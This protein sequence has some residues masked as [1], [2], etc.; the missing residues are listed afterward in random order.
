MKLGRD[1]GDDACPLGRKTVPEYRGRLRRIPRGAEAEIATIF[2]QCARIRGGSS[3]VTVIVHGPRPRMGTKR[4]PNRHHERPGFDAR[5]FS[6]PAVQ[7]GARHPRRSRRPARPARGRS[8]GRGAGGRP[9]WATWRWAS[10]TPRSRGPRR[11][12]A[13]GSMCVD[14]RR[15][16]RCPGSGHASSSATAEGGQGV[17]RLVLAEDG[18]G[19]DAVRDRVL[20]GNCRL[21]RAIAGQL[22]SGD[23]ERLGQALVP[24]RDG[25]LE[26]GLEH[27]DGRP[28][29]WAAPSTTMASAVRC[30]S[31]SPCRKIW[32][33]A[34][35]VATATASPPIR[36]RRTRSLVRSR[37]RPRDTSCTSGPSHTST[38]RCARSGLRRG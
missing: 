17:V 21:G 35:P 14:P 31:V 12:A 4:A 5:G 32:T 7:P 1:W 24:E 28:S 36:K 37:V 6:D 16:R 30:S 3:A 13:P 20:P 15:E 25:V 18:P 22:A 38:A 23:D 8:P 34:T 27:G 26:P 11:S 10:R 19:R 2:S 29:Y 33:V 9:R